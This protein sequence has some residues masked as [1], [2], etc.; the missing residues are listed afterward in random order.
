[1]MTGVKRGCWYVCVRFMSDSSV[2]KTVSKQQDT[3][4][5]FKGIS[6]FHC[7][8]TRPSVCL[9]V[10]LSVCV[11]VT[12][13]SV[14]LSL[15]VSVCLSVCLSLSVLTVSYVDIASDGTIHRIVSNFA[16]LKA[17]RIVS[18]IAII[19]SQTIRYFGYFALLY[20]GA[21]TVHNR[22]RYR[23]HQQRQSD[24]RQD[25][26]GRAVAGRGVISVTL[27]FQGRRMHSTE[28]AG[29]THCQ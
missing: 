4:P 18:N 11:S 10:R 5:L 8:V 25:N 19:P 23:R 12:S 27:T 16:I 24:R 6:S 13:Q 22:S 2:V 21:L 9:C 26:D 1:M 14:C 20:Y 3:S 17:Y 7:H 15:C 29:R 28:A